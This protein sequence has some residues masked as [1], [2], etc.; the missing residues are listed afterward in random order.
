MNFLAKKRRPVP[1]A[2]RKF[3][4]YCHLRVRGFSDDFVLDLGS[5]Q[6]PRNEFGFRNVVGIDIEPSKDSA[7]LLAD[8]SLG[9]IPVETASV[10]L[11][12]AYDF[13]EHI[14]RW[15]RTSAGT[16]YPFVELMNEIHRV[17]KPGGFFYSETPAF[18][19]PEAFQDPTHVNII[20]EDTFRF[21][22]CGKKNWASNYGFSGKF[23]HHGQAWR[24][25]HLLVLLEK[26]EVS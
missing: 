13:V 15:E 18:P 23:K 19:K 6:T 11:V 17:L 14:P 5:G 12:T 20:S 21:Y 22:F 3:V 26:L 24:G 25:P 9:S 4:D 2:T 16:R 8:L 1:R 7:V 10:D